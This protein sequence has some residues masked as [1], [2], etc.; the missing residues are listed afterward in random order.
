VSG[1]AV[2]VVGVGAT[3]QGELQGRTADDLAVEAALLALDDAGLTLADV[4]GLVTCKSNQGGIDTTIGRL[5]GINPRYSATLD[6][7][8]CNFSLHL[9]VMAVEAGMA[10][11]V[12]LAYGANHR[13]AARSFGVPMGEQALTAPHGFVHIAGPAAMAFRR[14]QYLYGTTEEQL[15]HVSVAQRRWAQLNPA[16]V[17]RT[18]LSIEDYLAQPYLVEPLR[19]A[20]VTMISDGGGAIVVTRADRAHDCRRLPVHVAAIAQDT[21]LREHLDTDHL[22]RP[23]LGRAA[24]QLYRVAGVGPADVQLLYVQDPT[25]V[26][27]L[28]M[29]EWYGF[30]KPGEAGPWLTEDHHVPGGSLPINTNGGQLSESYMWGWLHLAEAVRQLRGD[31]GQRQVPDAHVALSCSTMMFQKAAATLLTTADV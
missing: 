10:D 9:A 4:D 20:D 21:A 7:G 11:T 29:L 24:A 8:S 26:W 14:H 25:A 2:A 19:R 15:G 3:E 30:C 31:C 23:M 1:T 22:M 12:L 13:T 28:Q 5:L 6:Y 27:V 18:P 17:F 16:A